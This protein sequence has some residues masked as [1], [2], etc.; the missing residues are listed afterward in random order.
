M[1]SGRACAMPSR[2]NPGTAGVVRAEAWL[3]RRVDEIYRQLTREPV[4]DR[5]EA[6]AFVP[7]VSC[8]SSVGIL[9]YTS[10]EFLLHPV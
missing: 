10:F 4:D 8:H 3:S 5:M 1:E 7:A 9:G 2:A 6:C